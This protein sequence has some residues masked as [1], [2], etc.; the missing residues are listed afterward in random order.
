MESHLSY[1][2]K[3]DQLGSRG[4]SRQSRLPGQR[5]GGENEEGR[6]RQNAY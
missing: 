4:H 1:T 3:V 5:Q 6:E 2:V